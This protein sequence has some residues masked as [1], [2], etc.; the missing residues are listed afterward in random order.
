MPDTD[1]E[2]GANREH[3]RSHILRA[4][5][6]LGIVQIISW[7]TTIYALAVLGAPISSD[8]GW[9]RSTV[10]AG[11]T[12]GLLAS[13]AVSTRIGREIDA[14]GAR[15]VMAAGGLLAAVMLL[16]LSQASN[17][18]VYLALWPGLGIAMRMVLYDAAFAALVQVAPADGRRSIG[19]LTLFGGFASTVFWPIGH[20]LAVWLGWRGALAVFAGLHLFVCVPLVVFGLAGT[21]G[22]GRT[23]PAASHGAAE[24]EGEVAMLP[25]A[26][27]VL[28]GKERR[29]AAWLFT[30][31]MSAN[32]FVFGALSAHLVAIIEHA[33]VAAATAVG[34][35]SLKGIAQVAGRAWEIFLARGLSSIG[36][37]RLAVALLPAA[38]LALMLAGA[39]LELAV[40]FTLLLGVSNGLVTIVKGA[41]PLAL[42]G[43]H[44]YGTLLGLLATPQLLASALAPMA[45][46]AI[47]D[48]AG[49]DAGVMVLLA[50]SLLSLAAMELMA[51]WHSRR[52]AARIQRA[53]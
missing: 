10:F 22:G 42:F 4:I 53:R 19:M 52:P 1:R 5:V 13:G 17:E 20:A 47:V 31:V 3:G 41:V 12:L 2:A 15:P 6:A 28:D 50:V 38:F 25:A 40:A 35:A 36:V 7:G 51:W 43:A 14:R 18:L 16:A 11:M 21:R 23:D 46:A 49:Y 29:I 9:S 44:G 45:F 48:V 24:T 39:R 30:V 34:L 26:H 37:G 33:G 27:D 32:A 8:T